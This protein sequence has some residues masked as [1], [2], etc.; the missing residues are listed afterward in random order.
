MSLSRCSYSPIVG[1]VN[2]PELVFPAVMLSLL[3]HETWRLLAKRSL[4]KRNL[5][6]TRGETTLSSEASRIYSRFE[7]YALSRINYQSRALAGDLLLLLGPN[8]RIRETV[9]RCDVKSRI[10]PVTDHLGPAL[11]PRTSSEG[12]FETPFRRRDV[13]IGG[14]ERGG[15]SSFAFPR[16]RTEHGEMRRKK[17][18]ERKRKRGARERVN[19]ESKGR[20]GNGSDGDK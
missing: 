19:D 13:R 17:G 20:A 7:H 9:M 2:G 8:R 1:I 16:L 10:V 18:K 6:A 15:R 3:L 11:L 14:T 4:Q 12:N 5:S